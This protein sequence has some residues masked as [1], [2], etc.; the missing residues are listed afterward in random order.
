MEIIVQGDKDTRSILS[1]TFNNSV[2][3]HYSKHMIHQEVEEGELLLN[4]ITGEVMLLTA[5]EY[6]NIM[7]SSPVSESVLS[8]LVQ[9]GFLVPEDCDENKN[10]EQLRAILRKR[11]KP[12]INFYNILPTTACNA[13]CFY[14]YE[15]GIKHKSMSIETAEKVVQFIS[16]NHKESGVRIAWFGGEPTLGIKCIDYIC[17]R[18]T[19][20]GI[21]YTSEMVSNAY[22]FDKELIKHAK[23]NWNLKTI[24]ITLDGTE[25]I[26]NAVKA[27]VY[28][29][30]NPYQRVIR[31][32][33]NFLD[34]EV[35]VNIR[36]NVDNHNVSNLNELIDE[37]SQRFS[38]NK[39]LSIYIR[40]LI[41]N[42]GEAPI[43]HSEEEKEQLRQQYNALQEKL[44]KNSW[45]QIWK[46]SLPKIRLYSCMA[47]DTYSI[48]ITPD[49]VLGKCEGCIY[50]NTVG[51]LDE[52]ITEHA[53]EE[54]WRERQWYEQC[55]TCPLVPSCTQLL[56]HCPNRIAVCDDYDRQ[57]R[58]R[59]SCEHMIIA[60]KKWKEEKN[61]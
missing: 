55:K 31:N 29:T 4:T 42:A 51:T 59:L 13:R 5:E 14:C 16:N 45:K 9:S 40:Q 25:E 48:Q 47:D 44:E 35:K 22:L 34:E 11:R 43:I 33:Q 1:R 53:V 27:Y 24:Q 49:G 50:E 7:Q 10:I 8:A 37:L 18:L 19:E 60:Y 20:I 38:G 52:G 28:S 57:R 17:S 58:I 21:N 26:Y 41:E 39:Y 32:I 46:F 61:L 23:V 6:N 54:W 12:L 30:E 15:H 36:L 2:C 3:Y 56:K